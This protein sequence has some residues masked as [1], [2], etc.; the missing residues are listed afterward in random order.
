MLNEGDD[1]PVRH[2]AQQ[3]QWL[4]DWLTVQ[5]V[6]ALALVLVVSIAGLGYLIQ[7]N[8]VEGGSAIGT[9]LADV[10][11]NVVIALASIAIALLVI[12]SLNV[13]SV[14]WHLK[15]KLIRELGNT[16][17]GIALRALWELRARGWLEDGSLRG[18]NL[19]KAN[20]RRASLIGGNLQEAVLFRADLREA[21]LVGANLQGTYLAWANLEEADLQGANLCGADL[22]RAN[23]RKADLQEAILEGAILQ[24]TDLEGATMNDGLKYED[25]LKDGPA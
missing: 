22:R 17:N 5:K 16:D 25:W 6:R 1:M 7:R 10:Y 9:I 15:A 20:L 21:D 11:V 8:G 14:E 24:D 3:R 12:D 4:G 2:K 18:A 23:L 19:M 13:R